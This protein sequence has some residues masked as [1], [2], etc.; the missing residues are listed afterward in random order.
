MITTGN[1]METV[2]KFLKNIFGSVLEIIACA[3]VFMQCGS[4]KIYLH[5]LGTLIARQKLFF[6]CTHA[7]FFKSK[8]FIIFNVD[9]SPGSKKPKFEMTLIKHSPFY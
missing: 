5:L 2:G 3:H 4:V 1:Y 6:T 7:N 8:K 9:Y